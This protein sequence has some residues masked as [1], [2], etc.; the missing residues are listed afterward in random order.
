MKI[1]VVEDNLVSRV[2]ITKVL[3]KFDY[4]IF[5]AGDGK[6]ALK[7]LNENEI[8]TVLT[9]WMMPEMNGLELCRAIRN[10]KYNNY[11]YIIIVSAKGQKKDVINALE[12]GADD[13]ITKPFSPD[14]L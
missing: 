4:D 5:E 8:N 9:D 2:V 6:S 3:S 10:K 13:Y 7:I 12:T 1:L 14:E 11:I